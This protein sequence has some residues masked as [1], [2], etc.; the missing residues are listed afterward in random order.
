[1]NERPDLLEYL[2]AEYLKKLEEKEHELTEEAEAMFKS[3]VDFCRFQLKVNPTIGVCTLEQGLGLKLADSREVSLVH[4]P[5]LGMGFSGSMPVT[6]PP[7]H[8][9]ASG[10]TS[11]SSVPIFG[12]DQK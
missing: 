5:P 4:L 2:F 1:M 8:A 3:F 11:V 6:T 9:A 10:I 12:A 7:M